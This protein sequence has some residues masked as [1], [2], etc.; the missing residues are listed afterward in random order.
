MNKKRRTTH[1][2]IYK[3]DH[4]DVKAKFPEIKMPDYFHMINRTNPLLQVE[5]ILRGNKRVKKQKR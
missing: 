1:I 4:D 2:R 3:S 5:A